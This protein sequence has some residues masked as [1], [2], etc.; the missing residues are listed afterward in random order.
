MFQLQGINFLC[1]GVVVVVEVAAAAAAVDR[2]LRISVPAYKL[3]IH[4]CNRS[5]PVIVYYDPGGL[6]VSICSLPKVGICADNLGFLQ[7]L[8]C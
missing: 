5:I 1:V 7:H 6:Q 2:L 8:H 4:A 3:G